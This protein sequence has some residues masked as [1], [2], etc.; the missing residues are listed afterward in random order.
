MIDLAFL[1]PVAIG[2]HIGSAHLPDRGQTDT[3]PGIYARTASGLVYGGYRN[4][5]RRTTVYVGQSFAVGPVDLTLALGT[6][7]QRKCADGNGF[8]RTYLA[9][10]AA[11]SYLVPVDLLGARPRIHFAPAWGGKSS[12]VFHISAEWSIK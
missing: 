12:T 2:L 11:V 10:I 7:Y 4:S 9:P 6:G 1:A 5:Y 8:T 3:N